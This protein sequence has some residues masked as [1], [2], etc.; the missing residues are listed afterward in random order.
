MKTDYIKG[1]LEGDWALF[2]KIASYFV[3]EVP[4][5]DREDFLHDLMMEMVKVKAKYEVKGK[6][7][8]EASL[9][10]VASYEL[11]GYWDKR[12]YRLFGLNCT[13]CTSEQRHECHT[14]RLPS[15]CP[16]GKARQLLSLDKPWENDDGDN[17]PALMELIAYNNSID[18]DAKLDARNILKV[19]PKRSV[20]IGYKIYAG[21]PLEA[22][23]KEYL[24]HWQK[25]HPARFNFSRDHLDER[26]LER[27]HKKPQGMT[28]SDLAMRL[29][30]PVWEVSWYLAPMIKK[31]EVIEVKRENTRG[32]PFS[33]L[34]FIAGA[35]KPEGEMVRTERDERIRQAYFVEGKSIK[36]I[37]REFHHTKRTVHRAIRSGKR[38]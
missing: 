25:T 32:R 1:E 15:E 27:L 23:E 33:P 31:G 12:R 2:A 21:I 22:K 8:T 18:L 20:Q 35:E 26:I 7:L 9:M 14:T 24:K 28:R 3:N 38:E 34:L 29:Q 36:Q 13:H 17:L 30:A 6:T 16:K 19:L 37:A 5:E 11:K 10:K 4:H